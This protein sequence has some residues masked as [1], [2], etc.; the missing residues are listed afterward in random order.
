MSGSNINRRGL[1]IASAFAGVVGAAGLHSDASAAPP[2]RKSGVATT[3]HNTAPNRFVEVGGVRYAYRRFGKP[4]GAPPILLLHHY[5]GT[6]D[7]WDPALTDG[8][9]ASRE[10]ILF[11]NRGVGLSSDQTP[12][13]INGMADDAHGFIR[14]LGLSQVDLLAFS[15]GGMV[16]QE[17]TLRYPGDIRK[18]ILAGTGPR[19]GSGMAEAK[20]NVVK[21]LT[22]AAPNLKNARPYLFFSQTEQGKA[23]AAAFMARTAERKVDLD[24]GSSMQTMQAHNE[25]LAEFGATAGHA[26]YMTRLQGLKQA[27]LVV[28]GNN[29][30]MVDTINSYEISQVIPRAELIIYPDAGHG[31]IFQYAP[32]FVKHID[33]FLNREDI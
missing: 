28:N 29:D 18:L 23:A 15:I 19:G 25:A 16:C 30:I 24:P 31:S 14:G 13:R 21:A 3:S 9:A 2:K 22:D 4:G 8:L 17:L 6:M 27:T 12:N 5:I 20:P 1:L 33:L 26:E 32:L 11:D 10:V 7:W